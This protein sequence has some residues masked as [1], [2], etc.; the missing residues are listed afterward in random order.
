MWYHTA[1]G[2]VMDLDLAARSLKPRCLVTWTHL[3]HLIHSQCPAPF[4]LH[5]WLSGTH[6]LPYVRSYYSW[7][8][9]NSIEMHKNGMQYKKDNTNNKHGNKGLLLSCI[10]HAKELR[11][12]VEVQWGTSKWLQDRD[13]K[14]RL[15]TVVLCF[16]Y[17]KVSKSRHSA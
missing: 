16:V 6:S 17:A 13:P 9:V 3:S 7:F 5:S 12:Y 4:I 11:C 1:D 15:Y 10:F 14:S 2:T 8:S